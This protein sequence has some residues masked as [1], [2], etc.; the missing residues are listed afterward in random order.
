MLYYTAKRLSAVSKQLALGR[1]EGLGEKIHFN[2]EKLV[3]YMNKHALQP[4]RDG[5]CRA[6]FL[7][8]SVQNKI[9]FKR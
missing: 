3:F 8:D 7:I 4:N 2:L 9:A 6:V 5:L 1:A